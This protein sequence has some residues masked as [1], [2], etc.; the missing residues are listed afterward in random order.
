MLPTQKIQFGSGGGFTGRQTAYLLLPNGQIFLQKDLDG[1]KF[2]E[3]GKVN[4]TVAKALYGR[5]AKFSK[6]P[7]NRPADMNNFL[8]LQN[9][10]LTYRWQWGMNT[11]SKDSTA[12]ALFKLHQDLLD[13]IP[14]LPVKK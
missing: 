11:Q 2:E 5:C 9:D 14:M 6:V 7:V 1:K 4:K 12:N 3:L 10:S 8:T 13:L